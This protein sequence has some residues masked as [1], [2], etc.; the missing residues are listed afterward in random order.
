M[1]PPVKLTCFV[2]AHGNVKLERSLWRA[3]KQRVVIFNLTWRGYF[4]SLCELRS[5]L[6]TAL[7]VATI[8]QRRV[9]ELSKT[10]LSR[11]SDLKAQIL[12]VRPTFVGQKDDLNSVALTIYCKSDPEEGC[13]VFLRKCANCVTIKKTTPDDKSTF[14]FPAICR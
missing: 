9:S 6:K 7:F 1:F 2:T 8:R 13:H 5:N 11:I 14:L 3:R 12:R 10:H 4:L